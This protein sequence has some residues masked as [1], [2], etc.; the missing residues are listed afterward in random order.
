VTEDQI[1]EMLELLSRALR[2]AVDRV[3]ATR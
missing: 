3:G 2:R 1:D